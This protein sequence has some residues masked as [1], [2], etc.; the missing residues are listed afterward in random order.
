[1]AAAAAFIRTGQPFEE[2]GNLKNVNKKS[3]TELLPE[4]NAFKWPE[5][6]FFPSYIGERTNDDKDHFVRNI[7]LQLWE[8]SED[9]PKTSKEIQKHMI[10]SFA[11]RSSETL[12]DIKCLRQVQILRCPFHVS[13]LIETRNISFCYLSWESIVC[14]SQ[15]TINPFTRK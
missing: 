14:D 2:H 7:I 8:N 11:K 4:S 12:Q 15:R 6:E 5:N 13:Y 9:I 3:V 10:N 1:M